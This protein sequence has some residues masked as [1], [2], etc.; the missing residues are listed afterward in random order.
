MLESLQKNKEKYSSFSVKINVT[1]AGMTNKDDQNVPKN[2][3]LRF[4]SSCRNMTLG[5]DKLASALEDDQCK[6]LTE[7]YMGDEVLNLTRRKGL[8]PY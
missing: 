6:G 7:F 5:L 1:L 3:Q 2:I 8:H 4:I